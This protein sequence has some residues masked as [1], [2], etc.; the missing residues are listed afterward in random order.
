[1]CVCVNIGG[2]VVVV[3]GGVDIR[4]PSAP[5]THHNPHPH[6]PDDAHTPKGAG[7]VRGEVPLGEPEAQ[8]E[9]SH[10]GLPQLEHGLCFWCGWFWLGW[11]GGRSQTPAHPHTL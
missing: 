2:V 9:A 4:V 8:G 5:I 3:V 7:V 1:M 10:D 6:P 11:E